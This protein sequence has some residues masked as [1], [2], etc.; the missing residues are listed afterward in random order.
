MLMN[1]AVKLHSSNPVHVVLQLP[2]ISSPF[3][4]SLSFS[5]SSVLAYG[6]LASQSQ[7]VV[8][9]LPISSASVSFHFDFM[10][11]Y[12]SYYYYYYCEIGA[13]ASSSPIHTLFSD[14]QD[15]TCSRPNYIVNSEQ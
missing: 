9:N 1:L 3:S 7:Q 5:V 12:K 10:A 13:H 14:V 6:M 15:N 11:L 8:P 2:S 4:P